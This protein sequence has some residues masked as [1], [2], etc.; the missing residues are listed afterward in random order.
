PGA[1]RAAAAGIV[2]RPAGEFDP[3]QVPGRGVAGD[4]QTDDVPLNHVPGRPGRDEVHPGPRV[5]GDQV[6]P[7]GRG[8]A[9]RGVRRA[10]EVDPDLVRDRGGP[11]RA[12]PDVVPLDHVSG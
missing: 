9:D 8:P 10:Q 5:P 2:R 1:G 4:V 12:G 3:G 6:P 7:P 11:G